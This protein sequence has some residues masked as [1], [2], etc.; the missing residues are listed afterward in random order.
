M[1]TEIEEIVTLAH[2]NLLKLSNSNIL[3]LGGSGFVGT[4]LLK[5]FLRA[6]VK[7]KTN[8]HLTVLTRNQLEIRRKCTG[9]ELENVRFLEQD[10]RHEFQG[11]LPIFSHVIFAATPSNKR[12]GNSDKKLVF[13]STVE[14]VRNILTF[15]ES[16]NEFPIFSHLSSGAVYGPAES[17]KGSISEPDSSTEN[18]VGHSS[19]SNAKIE[20]EKLVREATLSGLVR[21]INPRLFAFAGPGIVLDEHFAI[22]NFLKDRLDETKIRITGN[23]ETIRSYLHPVD[24]CNWLIASLTSSVT[25]PIH[26]GSSM[27]ITMHEL[28]EKITSITKG[29]GIEVVKNDLVRSIY[30]PETRKTE[31]RLLVEQSIDRDESIERWW[32]WI[33]EN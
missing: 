19:Y 11:T 23:P 6:N 13:D 26:I 1:D 2:D 10:I 18:L 25:F 21:G 27:P 24:M 15:L 30:Y 5:T 29:K 12:T 22:G 14:G 9:S 8:I 16:Q 4:W 33:Q 17:H 20:A 7:Y 31:S 32:R 3:F 28:A